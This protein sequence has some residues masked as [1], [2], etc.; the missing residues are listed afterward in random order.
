MFP[1]CQFRKMHCGMGMAVDYAKKYGLNQ[2]W[3]QGK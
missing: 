3:K 1:H 2:I